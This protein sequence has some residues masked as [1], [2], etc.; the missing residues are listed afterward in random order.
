[1]VRDDAAADAAASPAAPTPV[2]PE[3]A[4]RDRP[5]LIHPILKRTIADLLADLLGLRPAGPTPGRELAGLRALVTGSTSG[6]GRAIALELAARRRR[7]D[8]SRP[9][10]GRRRGSHGRRSASCRRARRRP[11][12]PTCGI[13]RR[14]CALADQAW[15]SGAAWTCC[16]NNAGAD[17]LT[18]AAARWPFERKL[19]ELLAVDVTATMRAGAG[20]RPAD[21]GVGRRR[22]LE[23]GLGPGRDRH[24]RR[25]RRIVRGRQRGGHGVQQAAWP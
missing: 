10:F 3:T 6:I 18:G 12:W 7:R 21:E 4:G 2:R 11:D 17:T 20:R 22:D 9:A 23:H 19:Q 24:G 1:M 13:G 14:A 8:R 5:G 16:V 25:Q 15:R